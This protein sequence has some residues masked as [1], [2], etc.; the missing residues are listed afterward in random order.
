MPSERT[1]IKSFKK[2]R[3]HILMHLRANVKDCER[4]D[5]GVGVDDEE[6]ST[7][8][9]RLLRSLNCVEGLVLLLVD[10]LDLSL[11]IAA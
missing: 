9:M 4:L 3:E 8:I 1:K 10:D 11:V 5:T 6:V 2:W 7:F